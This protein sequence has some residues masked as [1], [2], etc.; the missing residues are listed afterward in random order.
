MPIAGPRLGE[1]IVA[2]EI[3][4]TGVE[5]KPDDDALVSCR[6]RWTWRM[7]D[8]VSARLAAGYLELGLRP[9]DRVASLMPNRTELLIHYLACMRSGLVAMPLNYRYMAPEI[10]HALRVGGP[11]VLLAHDERRG[12]LAASEL[13]PGLPLGW[14]SYDD[15]G[16][17]GTP[18][19]ASLTERPPAAP[20]RRR[21]PA[22]RRS[23]SS[24]R[25]APGSRR[26]CATASRRWAG[27]S[28]APSGASTWDATT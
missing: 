28:P 20:S 8:D 9:G 17:S 27:S 15:D 19:F 23:C 21:D 1:P 2:H 7:L 10:D 22:T 11:K 12:D 3:L 13:A 5:S 14:I 26:G 24:P 4:R 25:A 18:S 6:E 16:G